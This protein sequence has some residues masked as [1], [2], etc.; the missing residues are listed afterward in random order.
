MAFT[1]KTICCAGLALL[2]ASCRCLAPSAPDASALS[3]IDSDVQLMASA[4]ARDVAADG[5]N[6]WLR[7]FTDGGEFFMANN[8]KL[9]FSSFEE[10]RTFLNKFSAGVAHLELTWGELRVDPV[11]PGVAVMASPYREVFTDPAGHIIRFEGYF[12][13]LAVKTKS[14]WKLRDAHWSSLMASP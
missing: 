14:G 1:T 6:A 8:G 2:L 4:I 13:G 7:Y 9:Q 10:A 5:P 11:A 12:T 3:G